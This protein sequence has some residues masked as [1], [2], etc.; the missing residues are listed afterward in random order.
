MMVRTDWL[1]RVASGGETASAKRTQR[2]MQAAGGFAVPQKLTQPR[3]KGDADGD[4]L[5]VE[6][7]PFTRILDRTL[8]GGGL[9]SANIGRIS[10]MKGFLVEICRYSGDL[11]RYLGMGIR[12]AIRC[13][14]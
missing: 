1:E 5:N 10:G 12:T 14:Q 3:N 8:N 7:V 9:G 2:R 11:A 13:I 6:P 4:A